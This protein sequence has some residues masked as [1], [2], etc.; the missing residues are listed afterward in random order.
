MNLARR[1]TAWR[2]GAVL[3]AVALSLVVA[4]VPLPYLELSPGPTYNTIGEI[5]GTPLIEISGTQTYPT[6]GHLDL[7]TVSER[8]GP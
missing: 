7:T 8:G 6:S 1:Q 3:L 4:F 5:D 2:A